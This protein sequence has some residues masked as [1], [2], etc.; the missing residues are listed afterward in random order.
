MK[1]FWMRRVIRIAPLYIFYLI[2]LILL[3]YVID[4]AYLKLTTFSFLEWVGIFAYLANVVFL[5]HGGVSQEFVILWSL[6]IEEQFYLIWPFLI[7]SME[8]KELRRFIFMAIGLAIFFRFGSYLYD[9]KVDAHAPKKVLSP[10]SQ[11]RVLHRLLLF[12]PRVLLG[13]HGFARHPRIGLDRE[14]PCQSSNQI[15]RKNLL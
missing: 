2:V 9:A 12:H 15:H 3:P 13:G 1:S 8:L 10:R 14:N 6:S 11:K 4:V 5:F 7:K